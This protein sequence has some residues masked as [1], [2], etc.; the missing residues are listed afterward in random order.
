MEYELISA[1]LRRSRI[2]EDILP[3]AEALVHSQKPLGDLIFQSDVIDLAPDIFPPHLIGAALEEKTVDNA[4]AYLRKKT[5][6]RDLS[7]LRLLLRQLRS[8]SKADAT[9]RTTTTHPVRFLPI[10]E[11][12]YLSSKEK[13]IVFLEQY[14][15]RIRQIGQGQ[16]GTLQQKI[17]AYALS[18]NEE[19]LPSFFQMMKAFQ[20]YGIFE[21]RDRKHKYPI[22]GLMYGD[23]AL[24][25]EKIHT[26][27]EKAGQIV[28]NSLCAR[29]RDY[30]DCLFFSIDFF[31]S[32]MGKIYISRDIHE[33]QIGMGL[34]YQLG[35]DNSASY[36]NSLI[37]LLEH[38][39]QDT[40]RTSRQNIT[41]NF[42]QELCTRN[43]IYGMEIQALR[44][45]LVRRGLAVD[46]TTDNNNYTLRLFGGTAGYPSAAA[47][48]LTD[49]KIFIDT[50]IQHHREELR[51]LGVEVPKVYRCRVAEL[52]REPTLPIDA[53][54]TA[55]VFIH[56]TV[57][58]EFKPFHVNLSS[59]LAAKSI[60]ET[61]N[62][63]CSREIDVMER[64]PNYVHFKGSKN[65]Y[66][67][68]LRA[69]FLLNVPKIW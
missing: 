39:I 50:I 60:N 61:L 36:Y 46:E 55:D 14:A 8:A 6:K 65:Y 66:P 41:L 11:I 35:V 62:R 17:D 16:Q 10:E 37:S 49:D 32:P 63:L 9:R 43:K 30:D 67:H 51:T 7:T 13:Y 59:V 53:L 54:Q 64:V 68:E 4:I 57:H 15:E 18:S 28:L 27:L 3:Q 22:H 1:V 56:P 20:A 47:R 12:A 33:Q 38:R 44:Q 25:P 52:M 34:Q 19:V 58:R 69:Y 23:K 31:L 5:S 42:D 21:Q 2:R 29:L 26:T 40:K 24:L 48:A 45:N